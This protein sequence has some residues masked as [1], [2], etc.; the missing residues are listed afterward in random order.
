MS[1]YRSCQTVRSTFFAAC[2]LACLSILSHLNVLAA[3]EVKESRQLFRQYC[4][5][6][7]EGSHSEGNLDLSAL[8][9]KNSFD[10]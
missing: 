3:A 1:A 5:D 2:V 7:H 8:Q 6:C 9:T 10:A 4:I